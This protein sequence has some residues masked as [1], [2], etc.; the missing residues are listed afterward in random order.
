MCRTG[1]SF[2]YLL[3]V[4]CILFFVFYIRGANIEHL[5]IAAKEKGIFFQIIIV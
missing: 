2:T 5:S 4:H 3:I 1:S